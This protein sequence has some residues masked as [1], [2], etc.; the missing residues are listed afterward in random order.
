MFALRPKAAVLAGAA[1]IALSLF[2][3]GKSALACSGENYIGTLCLFGGNFDIRGYAFARGQLLQISLYESLF[4]LYGTTYGGDGRVNF[5]LPDLRGRMPVGF[6]T[7]PGL[8]PYNLG[9]KGGSENITPA[10][11]TMAAHTHAATAIVHAQSATATA[12]APFNNVWATPTREAY[13]PSA[14]NVTMRAG[15]VTV[16]NA[17]TG[18]GETI[19][20]IQPYLALN[21]LVALQG[22]YPSRN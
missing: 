10:V 16:T 8:S 15:A 11:R 1:A 4:S 20:N 2:S 12:T 18:G 9:Q 22:I 17:S 19:S 14:P 6:G 5:G 21:W 13:S 3:P 7:G